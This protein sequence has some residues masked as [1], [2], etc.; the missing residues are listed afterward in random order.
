MQVTCS[1]GVVIHVLFKCHSGHQLCPWAD[2]VLFSTMIAHTYIC[3]NRP[4][5]HFS[6]VSRDAAETL[7][8]FCTSLI[9]LK[10]LVSH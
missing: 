1:T 2:F 4:D 8:F 10:D 7:F 9:V 6:L 3:K 5:L